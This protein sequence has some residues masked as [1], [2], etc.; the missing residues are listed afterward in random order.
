MFCGCGCRCFCIKIELEYKNNQNEIYKTKIQGLEDD[1]RKAK[2]N[3]ESLQEQ[4]DLHTRNISRL[5]DFESNVRK[6]EEDLRKS[7]AVRKDLQENLNEIENEREEELKIVQDALDEA[8]QEREE[9]ILTFQ[10]ELQQLN[11]TNITRE[12]QMMEDFEWKLREMEKEHKKKLQEKDRQLEGSLNAVRSLVESELADSLMKV[13][14]DRRIAEEKLNEVGHLRSY[15]AEAI[16]LR[17]VTHEFQK[18][19]RASAREMENLRIRERL[20]EE[21]VRSLKTGSQSRQSTLQRVKAHHDDDDL[22]HK[23]EKMKSELNS[24][25]STLKDSLTDKDAY[26][27][28]ELESLRTTAD[29]DIWDLRMKLQRLTESSFDKQQQMEE[30]HKEEMD[31]NER[32]SELEI[33]L[34]TRDAQAGIDLLAELEKEHK[35]QMQHLEEQHKLSMELESDKFQAVEDARVIITKHH[36][37]IE[38]NL[39][40]QLNE[41]IN[42]SK[43][44]REEIDLLR[45]SLSRKDESLKSLKEDLEKI[46]ESK[47]SSYDQ[48]INSIP[49]YQPSTHSGL[50]SSQFSLS[51]SSD[52]QGSRTSQDHFYYPE[53]TGIVESLDDSQRGRINPQL[54]PAVQDS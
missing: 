50:S 8:A 28:K 18:A 42:K 1:L 12:Q 32:I 10:K 33:K 26:Y 16:Q 52:S 3:I 13:A 48:C 31:Y 27:H 7:E 51:S 20:L 39:K 34:A 23:M 38:G 41:Y 15:E 25:I 54:I 21:E 2:E 17:G 9:L 19:L 36:E 47:P 43:E 37:Y 30:K 46:Q 6:L 11:S 53:N 29:R 14:E 5:K 45:E 49:S 24:K 40:E 35:N 22:R 44:Y 4:N